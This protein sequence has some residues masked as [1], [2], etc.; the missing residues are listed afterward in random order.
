[1]IKEFSSNTKKTVAKIDVMF[2]NV[3]DFVSYQCGEDITLSD[4]LKILEEEKN[5]IPP[6][7]YGVLK[8]MLIKYAS[9]YL[10]TTDENINDDKTSLCIYREVDKY[11]K[12][13]KEKVKETFGHSAG[14]MVIEELYALIY[15][16]YLKD[17]L[18]E[19]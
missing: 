6:H 17:V 12:I 7:I 14:N 10:I 11:S 3:I 18:I 5:E 8:H 13:A 9:M 4:C 19:W 1:M 2:Q 15:E 16:R